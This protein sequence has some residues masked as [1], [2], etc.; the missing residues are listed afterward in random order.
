[1]SISIRDC[2]HPLEYRVH[3]QHEGS[4]ICSSCSLVLNE[5]DCV[6]HEVQR[7]KE[8]KRNRLR[9]SD[10]QLITDIC[11][12]GA[13]P[14][15][16]EEYAVWLFSILRFEVKYSDVKKSHLAVYS[17]YETLH[18]F[19]V[20]RT[21]KE[22]EAISGISSKILW[23][24]ESKSDMKIRD[25]AASDYVNRF[26]HNLNLDYSNV[27]KIESYCQMLFG[28]NNHSPQSLCASVIYF[29]IK[30]EKLSIPLYKVCEISG[31][32]STCIRQIN[33]KLFYLS[34]I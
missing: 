30:K 20:P 26:C 5:L 25:I 1:M 32:S 16:I 4:E 23:Q 10:E 24:I 34:H 19:N 8:S 29:H 7:Y 17:L 2:I 28:M 31:V 11:R 6:H 18:R 9:T 12:N 33:R 3:D 15:S 14:Q 27:K 21:Y 13:I 22:I